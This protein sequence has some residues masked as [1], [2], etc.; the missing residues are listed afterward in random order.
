[1][2]DENVRPLVERMYRAL[3][4]GDRATLLDVLHPD[5]DGHFSPG[6][7]EPIGGHH[8]GAKECIDQGWWAIGA[9]WA[10]R[11][12][13]ERWLHCGSAELLVT[14]TYVGKARGTGQKVNAPFAHLW[15]ADEGRLRTLHQYTDTALWIDSL[16]AHP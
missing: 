9:K 7:P 6:L 2:T 13:P 4:E 10:M 1:M 16:E 14:G 11:A 5:F 15:A 12:Q 8:R 3:G